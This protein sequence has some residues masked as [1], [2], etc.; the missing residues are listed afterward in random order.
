VRWHRNTDIIHEGCGNFNAYFR[1][2]A[3]LCKVYGGHVFFWLKHTKN[4]RSF[5]HPAQGKKCVENEKRKIDNAKCPMGL[6]LPISL[7]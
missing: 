4:R 6:I 3:K 7:L 5:Q 2:N 1:H